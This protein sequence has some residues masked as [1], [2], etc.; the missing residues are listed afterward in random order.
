MPPKP[1]AKN[2]TDAVEKIGKVTYIGL[3]HVSEKWKDRIVNYGEN[4]LLK[5]SYLLLEIVFRRKVN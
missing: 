3:N 5:V 1:S 2:V 4:G